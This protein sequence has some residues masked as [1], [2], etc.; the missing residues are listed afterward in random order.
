MI[1]YFT[2]NQI[3]IPAGMHRRVL[4]AMSLGLLFILVGCSGKSGVIKVHNNEVDPA[5]VVKVDIPLAV[6]LNEV[7]GKSVVNM[8]RTSDTEYHFAPGFHRVILQYEEVWEI[9]SDDHSVIKSKEITQEWNL[10]PGA[11]YQLMYKPASNLEE[12]KQTATDFSPWIKMISKAD[13][14][15]QEVKAALQKSP[16]SQQ[17]QQLKV[18]WERASEADRS[19]F[20]TWIETP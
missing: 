5:I 14:D 3:G 1:K 9:G 12:S 16:D 13:L 11:Q 8:L 2:W 18:W 6:N 15:K 10:E 4:Y 17:L 19:K 7:D 20:K